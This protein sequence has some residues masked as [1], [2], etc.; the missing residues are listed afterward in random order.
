M[1]AAKIV[2]AIPAFVATKPHLAIR[3]LNFITI[4]S[5]PNLVTAPDEAS[6]NERASL[7]VASD[8]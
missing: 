2:V 5:F 6:N 3:F 1:F 4:D 7:N 8:G